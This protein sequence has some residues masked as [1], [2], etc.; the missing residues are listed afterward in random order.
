MEKNKKL[1]AERQEKEKND[2]LPIGAYFT[3]FFTK[4]CEIYKGSPYTGGACPPKQEHE[5][6]PIN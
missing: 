3:F 1:I 4:I 6:V 2:S 5:P